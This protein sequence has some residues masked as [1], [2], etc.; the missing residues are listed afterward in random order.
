M[1]EGN[2]AGIVQELA[3]GYP[4]LMSRRQMSNGTEN[5]VTS[6]CTCMMGYD[7]GGAQQS[8]ETLTSP[9]P[10]GGSAF[11]VAILRKPPS[12]SARTAA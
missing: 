12:L 2:L 8:H 11:T 7:H 1:A 5:G 4:L 10:G 3:A 6:M 9:V